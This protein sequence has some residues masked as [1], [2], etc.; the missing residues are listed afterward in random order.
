MVGAIGGFFGGG[1]NTIGGN[2]S[3]AAAAAAQSGGE[4]P[5]LGQWGA[6]LSV[7]VGHRL[8]AMRFLISG[9]HI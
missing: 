4:D 2:V 8:V 9:L 7:L 1:G 3:A 6:N 5:L